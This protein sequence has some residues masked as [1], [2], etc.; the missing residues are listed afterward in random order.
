MESGGGPRNN[1]TP[2]DPIFSGLFSYHVSTNTWTKLRDDCTSV[3]SPKPN[4]IKSRIGHS[5]LFHS[6]SIFFIRY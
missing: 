3:S 4:E 1:Y 5:M 2:N 6:V